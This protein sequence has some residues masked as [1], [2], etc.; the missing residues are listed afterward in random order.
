MIYVLMGK[1]AAGKDTVLQKLLAYKNICLKKIVQYTTRPI[2]EME[3]NG[4]EYFF[5]DVDT[6]NR[7]EAEGKIVEKRLY[8]TVYGEWYYFTANEALDIKNQAY[9]LIG[10]L[11]V[12]D[13]LREYYGREY[14]KG[15]LL[16]LDDGIRLQR[17]LN[18]E[19]KVAKPRY[20][21]MCRRFL[22]DEEDFS[23][24]KLE[25]ASVEFIL[26]NTDLSDTLNA[27][28]DFIKKG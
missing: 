20:A 1:S 26:E 14:V 5:V 13:K 12:L 10:T 2:K 23:K 25:K 28:V 17:A 24:E 4:R 6:M 16:T 18:R 3:E 21:E 19:K 9:I 22:S 11:E 7:L 8:N 15:I 27:I